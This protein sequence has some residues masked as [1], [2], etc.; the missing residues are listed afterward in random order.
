MISEIRRQMAQCWRIEPG[1]RD[2]ANLVVEIRV[3]LNQD[4]SV[5]DARILDDY[6]MRSDT[7]FRSAAE[8][9]RRAIF[10]CS[11]FRLPPRKFEIW[12]DMTFS[13]NPGRMFG[14]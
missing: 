14:G 11:P 4:G 13:F 8:N 2:A 7:F 6:R 10:Q 9:A 12:R 5:R 1:A 3:L